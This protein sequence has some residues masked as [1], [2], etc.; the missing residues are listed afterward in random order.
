MS[1]VTSEIRENSLVSIQ[2]MISHRASD[3]LLSVTLHGL[4]ANLC[5]APSTTNLSLSTGPGPRSA[6]NH[7]QIQQGE[8]FVSAALRSNTPEL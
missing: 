4:M 2:R 5:G 3:L 6:G 1:C 8:V 7:L